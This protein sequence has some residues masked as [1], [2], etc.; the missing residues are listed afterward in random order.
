M[1]LYAE[2]TLANKEEAVEDVKVRGSLGCSD[3]EVVE[4]RILR[5]E[6]KANRRITALGFRR[7]DSGQFMDLLGGILWD[8][9]LERRGLQEDELIFKDLFFQTQEQSIP[10]MQEILVRW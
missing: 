6:N 3:N 5:E 9:V 7:A 1:R 8:T 2:L 10:H 4:F